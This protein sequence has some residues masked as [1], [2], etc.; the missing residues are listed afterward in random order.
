MARCP[1]SYQHSVRPRD[2]GVARMR[3]PGTG[4]VKDANPP[5]NPIDRPLVKRARRGGRAGRRPQAPGRRAGHRAGGALGSTPGACSGRAR[6]RRGGARSAPNDADLEVLA[7]DI[8]TNGCRVPVAICDD[9]LL[10]GRNRAPAQSGCQAPPISSLGADP[11]RGSHRP[12]PNITSSPILISRTSNAKLLKNRHLS[13]DNI[14]AWVATHGRQHLSH[15]ATSGT[16]VQPAVEDALRAVGLPAG[17]PSTAPPRP[18]RSGGPFVLAD[19]G[20]FTGAA[21]PP[22]PAPPA[23]RRPSRPSTA[24]GARTGPS[25]HRPPRPCSAP[26]APGPPRRPPGDDPSPRT[27]SL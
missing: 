11:N 7:A 23:G 24:G 5:S 9:L 10:D 16:A 22:A 12:D 2:S 25:A 15:P 14:P 4:P 26:R 17:K 8:R 13:H 18:P 3:P 1:R 21:R 20:P 6:P 27:P 19:S